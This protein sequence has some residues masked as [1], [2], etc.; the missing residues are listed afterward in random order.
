MQVHGLND[1][2]GC[3]EISFLAIDPTGRTT[4]NA[5]ELNTDAEDLLGSPHIPDV[6]I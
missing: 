6:N 5:S 2:S 1:D 4:F 3:L